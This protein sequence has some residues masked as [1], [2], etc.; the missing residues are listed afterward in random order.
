MYSLSSSWEGSHTT[1]TKMPK[2]QR[3]GQTKALPASKKQKTKPQP[4]RSQRT[5]TNGL[6][7]ITENDIPIAHAYSSNF[8]SPDI[9]N[10]RSGTRIVHKELVATISG[11]VAYAVASSYVANP[12]LATSFPWLSTQASSWEQYRFHRLEYEFVPSAAYTATGDVILAPDYDSVDGAPASEV[13]ASSYR[14]GIQS[15]VKTRCA[16]HLD[17]SAMH[18]IGPRKYVRTTA[19]AGVD[20]K[21]YDAGQLHFATVGQA[22]TAPVGRLWVHYDVELFVPQLSSPTTPVATTYSSFN[23]SSAQTFTTATPATLAF[24]EAVVNGL[25]ITNSSG[26]FT[27]PAGAF[28]IDGVVS[29]RDSSSEAFALTVAIEKDS[30]AIDPPALYS[31]SFSSAAGANWTST[32]PFTGYVASTGSNTV[33]V[34]VTMTG[35]AGTLTSLVDAA[36]VSFRAV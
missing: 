35:A 9:K 5:V 10:S 17:P 27:L 14:D 6:R 3:D 20:L 32:V 7:G 8:R 30:A 29:V 2:R 26:V 18:P 12:G 28:A 31:V 11:S 36:R 15:D 24:D 19:I 16:I 23:R 25:G 21:T 13:V 33:R 4:G 1:T 34:R 22:D